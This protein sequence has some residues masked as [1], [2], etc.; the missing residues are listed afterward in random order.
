MFI[1]LM[2]TKTLR[3]KAAK[4]FKILKTKELLQIK[5]EGDGTTLKDNEIY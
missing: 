3:K 4:G 2:I 5:G 1:K